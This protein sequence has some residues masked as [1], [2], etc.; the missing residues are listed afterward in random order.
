MVNKPPQ[1]GA[2][3]RGFRIGKLGL[4]LTGSYLGYQAQNL[5]LGESEQR[6]RQFEQTSSR[7]VRQELG[8]LRER[9]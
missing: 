6:Q 2:L 3:A 4:S 7:R 9:R 8:R 1:S 5:F